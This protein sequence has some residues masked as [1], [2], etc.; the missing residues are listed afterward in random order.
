MK[1][2]TINKILVDSSKNKFGTMLEKRHF[3]N[4]FSFTANFEDYVEMGKL[5]L[6]IYTVEV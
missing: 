6:D 4:D 1:N 3:A 2:N 5:A